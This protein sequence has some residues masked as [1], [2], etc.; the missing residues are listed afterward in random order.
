MEEKATLEY[1]DKEIKE[2][3]PLSTTQLLPQKSTHELRQAKQ[4]ILRCRN[5]QK[6]APKM[7]RERKNP[8]QKEWYNPQ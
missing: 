1:S 8:D 6:E 7:G 2:T 5:K 3:A 4:S